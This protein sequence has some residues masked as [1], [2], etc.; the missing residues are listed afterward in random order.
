MVSNFRLHSLSPKSEGS[1][2][3]LGL[4]RFELGGREAQAIAKHF[5]VVLS[6]QRGRAFMADG[7]F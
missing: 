6:Q 1:N 2:H 5:C 3:A 7:R 4:E